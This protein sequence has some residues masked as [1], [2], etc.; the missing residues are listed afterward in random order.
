MRITFGLPGRKCDWGHNCS[1]REIPWGSGL[2][3]DFV[4]AEGFRF[5]WES[6]VCSPNF[7]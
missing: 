3:R 6:L 2:L 1:R 5:P 7:L 4:A